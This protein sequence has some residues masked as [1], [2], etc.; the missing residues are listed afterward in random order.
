MDKARATTAESLKDREELTYAFTQT[1]K[2][3]NRAASSKQGS[4]GDHALVTEQ[5]KVIL[6][7]TKLIL[8]KN[9]IE[10]FDTNKLVQRD[11]AVD[12]RN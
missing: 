12:N 1:A 9:M 6:M 3:I 10:I 8:P 5:S 7:L 11:R 2:K 4:N